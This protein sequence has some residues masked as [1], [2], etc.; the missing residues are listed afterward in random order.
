[1]NKKALVNAFKLDS[2]IG[3]ARLYPTTCCATST[4]KHKKDEKD[5]T[6][7]EQGAKY[8]RNFFYRSDNI[9]DKIYEKTIDMVI[10]SYTLFGALFF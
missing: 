10:I 1:M 7:M 8:Y 9:H 6:S 3:F 2:D 4:Q 5:V